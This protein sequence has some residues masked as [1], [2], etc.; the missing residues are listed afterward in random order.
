MNCTG[1]AGF[2]FTTLW[3]YTK[4]IQA[5]CANDTRLFLADKTFA[6]ARNASLTQEACVTFAGSGWTPYPPPDIWNRLTTWKFP[7]L[8]LVASFPRPPLSRSVEC[9]VIL[10]LLG[11]PIDA[12]EN[13]LAKLSTCQFMADSWKKECDVLLKP[14]DRN[15][16]D[17]D[18][19]WKALAIVTDAYAE[20]S[21]SDAAENCLRSAL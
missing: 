18:R 8:Q 20:W 15:D 21:E 11:D 19:D 6:S 4:S 16:T 14:R 17:K 13:L 3:N 12:I 1:K 5:A 2:R 10:H 9:L 7:L